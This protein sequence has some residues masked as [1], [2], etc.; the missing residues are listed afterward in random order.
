MFSRQKPPQPDCRHISRNRCRATPQDN[1]CRDASH[2]NGGN[3]RT[4]HNSAGKTDPPAP[5]SRISHCASHISYCAI[6]ISLHAIH[7]SLHAIHIRFSRPSI[8]INQRGKI[9]RNSVNKR[10]KRI[11]MSAWAYFFT[12]LA[13]GAEETISSQS[14]RCLGLFLILNFSS[15]P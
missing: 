2:A 15:F 10:F 7:I 5:A 12:V 14:C 11:I 6:H 9:R 13:D 4:L 3:H 1:T 8:Y